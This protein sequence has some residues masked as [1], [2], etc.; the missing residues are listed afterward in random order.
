MIAACPTSLVLRIQ[1]AQVD[2]FDR[3]VDRPDYM[4]FWYQFFLICW[5]QTRLPHHVGLEDYF[6]MAVFF[7]TPILLNFS[8]FEEAGGQPFWIAPC[9]ISPRLD[10]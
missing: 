10:G 5:H 3:L 4:I 9:K 7:H 1:Q 8:I 6:V 2:L